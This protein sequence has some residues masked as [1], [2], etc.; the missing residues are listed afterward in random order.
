MYGRF[1]FYAN[2][3]QKLFNCEKHY[4]YCG[5]ITMSVYFYVFASDGDVY[6]VMA[7]GSVNG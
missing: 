6:A 1:I 2:G 7:A 4:S 5:V 3:G